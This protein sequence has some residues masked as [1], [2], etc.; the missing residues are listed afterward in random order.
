M[1]PCRRRSGLARD[2]VLAALTLYATA[3]V[4]YQPYVPAPLDPRRHAAIYA[5]RDLRDENLARFLGEHGAATD[6]LTPSALALAAI[7]FR[8]EVSE[9]VQSLRVAQAGEITAGTRPFPSAGTSVQH[10]SSAR[11][12]SPWTISLTTGLTFETG[13]KRAARLS[14]A[15]A[16]TLATGLRLDA[17]AWRLGQNA[18]QRALESVA[19]VHDLADAEAEVAALRTVLEL[20]RAR[21][22]EG[23]V[24]LAD[25]AQTET[26]VQTAVVSLVQ[27]RRA[28][29]E[30]RAR[31]A[32]SLGVPLGVISRTALREESYSACD[33]VADSPSDSVMHRY[34]SGALQQRYEVGAALADY[35]VAES[36]LRLAFAKQ[37]PDIVI[38]PGVV[39]DQGA[40]RWLLSAG[41]QAIPVNRNRG[42]IAEAEARR[43]VAAAHVEVVQDSVLAQVDSAVAGCRDVRGEI[44]AA[45]SLVAA[46]VERLRLS[47]SAYARG[48]IGET[49]VAFA[50]LALVR[51]T[52]TR[53][54]AQQRRRSAGAALEAVSGRFLM[55]PEIRWPQFHQLSPP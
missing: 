35:L 11:G 26:D 40:I 53:R 54:Q 30:A 43:A 20:L 50:R 47:E 24:S 38:G 7:F 12:G 46:T 22:A 48:E 33:S 44:A 55:V 18:R 31:L 17:T 13:G 52:R 39:W 15:R 10:A 23:R 6:S 34:E 2:A 29:T 32:Q 27:A 8:P 1:P 9:A 16:L 19:L 21:Y 36:D 3:C 5:T 51:A 49:E 37:Y 41:S 42:P 25:I 45:D 28:L 14:R 4:R